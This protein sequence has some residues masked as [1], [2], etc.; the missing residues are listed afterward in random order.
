MSLAIA[1]KTT[2]DSFQTSRAQH[3]F[4]QAVITSLK[5]SDGPSFAPG[6]ANPEHMAAQRALHHR[7]NL[8][9]LIKGHPAARL[10]AQTSTVFPPGVSLEGRIVRKS[11]DGLIPGSARLFI[12]QQFPSGH[13]IRL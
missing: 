7:D 1:T 3:G 4:V 2:I 11:H 8:A 5:V 6:Q 12:R 9:L 13:E 10:P